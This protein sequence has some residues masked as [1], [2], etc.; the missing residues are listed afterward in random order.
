MFQDDPSRNGRQAVGRLSSPRGACGSLSWYGAWMSPL[1]LAIWPT[2]AEVPLDAWVSSL[3]VWPGARGACTSCSMIQSVSGPGRKGALDDRSDPGLS[4]SAF[5]TGAK[6][7]ALIASSPIAVSARTMCIAIL[8]VTDL[9]EGLRLTGSW[10]RADLRA[11][12][13]DLRVE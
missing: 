4:M 11:P 6:A 1:S 13:T 9:V 5:T 10:P 7:Q 3:S 8:L 2:P 12:L